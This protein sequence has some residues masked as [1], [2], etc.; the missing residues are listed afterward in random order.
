HLPSFPNRRS[1]DLF[2]GFARLVPLLRPGGHIV[3]G[4]YNAYGRLMTDLRR[5]VFRA[6]GGAARWIDPYLRSVPM[7]DR[8]SDAWFA[9]QYLHP[10]ES[11]H[12][13][14]EVLGWFAAT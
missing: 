9:D 11:T 7:S 2:G 10:H 4:L 12:T 8:K 6:T 14:G 13:I 5:G 3:V 1:S